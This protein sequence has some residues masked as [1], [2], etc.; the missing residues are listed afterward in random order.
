MAPFTQFPLRLLAFFGAYAPLWAIYGIRAIPVDWRLAAALGAVAIAFPALILAFV[1]RAAYDS[2]GES[3]TVSDVARRDDQVMGYLFTYVLPFVGLAFSDPYEVA[4]SAV[5]VLVLLILY[6][7]TNLFYVNPILSA[8]GYRVYEI[9]VAGAP[10]RIALSKKRFVS[11]G[12]S[13]RLVRLLD[14]DIFLDVETRK[15]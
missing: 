11:V 15:K 2:N 10:A 12:Q 6:V 8:V 1:H 9:Q 3:T 5:F 13:L 14:H 7:R 4:A